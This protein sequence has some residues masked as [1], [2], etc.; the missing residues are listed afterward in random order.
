[1]WCMMRKTC[2]GISPSPP[3]R[4]YSPLVLD[5]ESRCV[6]QP[7]LKTP[8]LPSSGSAHPLPP[9]PFSTVQFP[10]HL[11]EHDVIIGKT[12]RPLPRVPR[13]A[14]GKSPPAA[15]AAAAAPRRAR[16]LCGCGPPSAETATKAQKIDRGS[17]VSQRK[18]QNKQR[19]RLII[20]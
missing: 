1:M 12:L 16:V 15:A 2:L 8:H 13:H 14:A 18:N 3:S 5:N 6:L 9:P 20:T 4:L 11:V 19:G 10:T 7:P 17:C